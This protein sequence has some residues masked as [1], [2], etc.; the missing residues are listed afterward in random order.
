[1]I[2]QFIVKSFELAHVQLSYSKPEISKF[3]PDTPVLNAYTVW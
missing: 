2:L 1:M 3:A